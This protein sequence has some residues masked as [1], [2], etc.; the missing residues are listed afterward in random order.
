MCFLQDASVRRSQFSFS[1]NTFDFKKFPHKPQRKVFKGVHVN[2]WLLILNYAARGM[3]V[4]VGIIWVSGLI[5]GFRYDTNLRMFGV[6]FILFGFYRLA[7][8]Y[9][10]QMEYKRYRDDDDE[11]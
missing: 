8:F 2:R 3:V 9:T 5:P 1:N 6:V 11:S 10:Q 7:T 4:V